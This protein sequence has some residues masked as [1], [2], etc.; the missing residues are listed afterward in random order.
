MTTIAAPMV[1]DTIPIIKRKSYLNKDQLPIVAEL[2]YLRLPGLQKIKRNDIVCFNWPIDT[3]KNM[4]YTDKYY[5][6]PID[7][8]TNYVK[9]AVGIAG[10]T[11][12]V[13]NGY[14]FINGEKNKLPDRA[15]LQFSY[16][17]QPKKN[18]FNPKVMINNYDITD[19][20]GPINSNYTY[21]FMGISEKSLLKLKNHTNV[22]WI[23]KDTLSKGV[24]D[25]SVF[26][27]DERYNWNNDF[28][29]PIY[30]PK[31]NSSIKIT[32]DNYPIYKRII[33]VYEKNKIDFIENKV[34]INGIEQNSYTFKQDYFWLMGDNR[35][36][37]QD[38]RSWGFVPFDHVVGKP[39]FKWLSIDY[40]AKGFNKIRWDRMFTTVHGEGEP[41]SYFLHFIAIIL[42]W[43][44]VSYFR[45][46]K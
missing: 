34:F 6:K 36:N 38:S 7:K 32:K 23:K 39:V 8:K 24:R 4:F 35:S 43:N 37:S 22:E 12:E 25:R 28:F 27:Q 14:V 30:I 46:K 21:K 11:L 31:K 44:I 29:G 20:F 5:Y 1:H 3:L 13:I 40:N 9:R 19:R 15:K 45:S 33:E 42:L 18:K 41:K 26:P 10:D 17:V 16:L 2:P